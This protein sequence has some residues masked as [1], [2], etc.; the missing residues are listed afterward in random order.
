MGAEKETVTL[1]AT[2]N[3]THTFTNLDKY[4]ADGHEIAYTVDETPIAGYTKAIS[5]T[6]ATGFT[7]TNTIT[8]KLDIPVTKVWVG[9][10]TDRRYINL[11]ADGVKVDTV[12]TNSS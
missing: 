6:A 3:W 9:P 1:T 2:E 8:G 10:A 12:Q 11:Y 4:G 5:G 7:V